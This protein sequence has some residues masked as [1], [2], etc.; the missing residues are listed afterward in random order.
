MIAD[1]KESDEQATADRNS[2]QIKMH[3]FV[4][5]QRQIRGGRGNQSTNALG[6]IVVKILTK[7]EAEGSGRKARKV[8]IVWVA[9]RL[10]VYHV[11]LVHVTMSIRVLSRAF[12]T[13]LSIVSWV[14]T[15]SSAAVD[16]VLFRARLEDMRRHSPIL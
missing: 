16:V 5:R 13:N 7:L 1:E 11:I 9:R 10:P 2:H 14:S 8:F 4:A 3:E 6:D 15:D 12:R